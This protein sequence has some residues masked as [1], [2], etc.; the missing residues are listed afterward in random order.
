MSIKTRK[1]FHELLNKIV[2]NGIGVEVGVE[3]GLYSEYLLS[4][5]NCNL[6][7][8]IDSWTYQP[9]SHQDASNID[10]FEQDVNYY[11]TKK[12]LAKFKKRSKIIRSYSDAAS[13]LMGDST[14]DFVY[15]DARHDFRSVTSDI[16]C[17]W[18]KVKYGGILGGHD[19]KDAKRRKNLV[20]V[21]RAVDSFALQYN[22]VV[23][24]TLE[25]N[26]TSWYIMK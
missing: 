14:L 17:W 13:R 2:P 21:K 9:D 10:Q 19:Y 7:Y 16:G 5:W 18:P 22:L 23:N 26:L 15:L 1:H 12:R 20:E 4:N 6:L 11:E 8:S 24:T 25:D 3:K